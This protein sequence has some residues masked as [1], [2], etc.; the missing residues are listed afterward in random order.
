M[1]FMKFRKFLSVSSLLR[2]F[3]FPFFLTRNGC[4][5]NSS[6]VQWLGFSAFTTV[7][8]G[9]LPGQGTRILQAMCHGQNIK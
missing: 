8:S 2:V 3:L 7:G 4:L 5:G 1:P 6:A 9:S